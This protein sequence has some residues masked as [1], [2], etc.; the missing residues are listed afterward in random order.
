MA[1][2]ISI[3]ADIMDYL[4]KYENGVLVLLSVNYNNNFSEGTLYYS[5]KMLAL[6]VDEKIEEEL[7]QPIELWDGYRDLLISVLKKVVPYNEMINR[8]DDIDFAN[9]FNTSDDSSD[10]QEIDDEDITIE[11]EDN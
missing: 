2:E 9:Y 7:G 3:K 4:G 11:G 6:T 8:L 10:G 1:D 5:D